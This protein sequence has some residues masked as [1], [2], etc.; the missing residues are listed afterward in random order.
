MG[1]RQL[2]LLGA[3]FLFAPDFASASTTIL[4]NLSSEPG[5]VEVRLV[6]APARLALLP[7]TMTDVYA[8]N[9]RIPG[10]LLEVN[11]G[12]RV[13]VRFRNDLPEPTT[14]HWHGLHLP[15]TAD[16][17][18]L[19]PI[20]PGEEHV[21]EF[22][23]HAGTAGTYWY[24]PHPHHRTGFQVA[25]GLYG[26]IIVRAPDDPLAH[27][28]EQL[29]VL[30]D[31][32]FLPDGALDFPDSGSL[33]G[34]IDFENGREGEVVFVNG[35]IMPT[36]TLRR[37]EI[38]RWR[39]INASGARVYRLALSGHSFLHVG[40]D[41]GLFEVP[42]EVD[43]IVLANG[44]R[45]EVLVRGTAA[46][47]TRA[48]LQALPYDRYV[49]QT[50]PAEWNVAR[51]LLAV[52]YSRE[53]PVR[54]P[55]VPGRLREI[56]ALDPAEASVTRVM[57]MTQGFLNNQPMDMQRVDARAQLGA[58]EIWE[59]ENLVGMDH[60]FHLHGFQFQVLDRN[61]VPEPFRSWQD[62]I[63]VPK[64]STARFIVRFD[65]YPGK[66]M[67][68]CHILAHE[69]EGMMG[70]LEVS[71][72]KVAP[73]TR[74]EPHADIGARREQVLR[75]RKLV[76]SHG[77]GDCHGG[78]SNPA[79]SGWLAGDSESPQPDR[80]S[81]FRVFARNL[82]PDLETGLGRYSARQIFNALRFGLRPGAAPDVEITSQTP[83]TGNHP[84]EPNY[85]APMM[86]WSSM[87][88]MSDQEIWDIVAYLK[89]GVKPA[90]HR[91]PDP[92]APSNYWQRWA[93][94]VRIGT[95][96]LPPFPTANEVTP[97]AEKREQVLHG[98]NLVAA[99]AC[100]EC[101]GG[102]GNPMVAGWMAGMPPEPLFDTPASFELDFEIGPFTTRARNLTPDNTSGI[103]RFTER[104]IFN[105]LRFGLRPGETADVEIT[106]TTPGEGNHPRHPKY[107]AP[108]MPWTA[109]RHLADEEIRA[110]A[111]Y[112]KHGLRPVRNRVPDSEGPPDF[113]FEMYAEEPFG[114]YPAPPFPTGN[115][116]PF[117][118]EHSVR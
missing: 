66:W 23:V 118:H 88:H 96:P 46:A 116:V 62:T 11:E 78:G 2:F 17:S 70:V 24:H 7:G 39:I 73:A 103:G 106:S 98:R 102:R 57:T 28:P 93:D 69:D 84:I 60:P 44:E 112:L 10:P 104:Q 71:A 64:H 42:V 83:G 37:G 113:W 92:E 54:S 38:Q 76:I 40:N 68:H 51:D 95:R 101:H 48:V 50:R 13:I 82:T 90:H 19:H 26:A 18:P 43:E 41:G 99:L 85:L 30:A 4:E 12:D 115:E 105:A 16:G 77:C 1:S 35:E 22:T 100:S 75:G 89:G 97:P 114:P 86:P 94:P 49:P 56:P 53:R 107:L 47:G 110:I 65:N 67:F 111:A 108:P 15:F 5:T 52:A 45:V 27:L 61:G 63:N 79:A 109:W 81:D 9:G 29:I 33:A 74:D 117:G 59:I 36:V 8:Y 32:R 72:E 6:A 87:R 21:Y 14:V 31:N 3:M 55:V 58:T 80:T 25:K 20:G 91:V 34:R